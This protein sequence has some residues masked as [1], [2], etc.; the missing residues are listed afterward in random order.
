MRFET[1]K[2]VLGLGLS[3]ACQHLNGMFLAGLLR[4][5]SVCL[6]GHCVIMM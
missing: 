5:F 4:S 2:P 1:H 6:L 3:W